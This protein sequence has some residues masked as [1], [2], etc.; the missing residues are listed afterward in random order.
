MATQQ[1]WSLSGQLNTLRNSTP[2]NDDWRKIAL[3]L[4]M[5]GGIASKEKAH[6]INHDSGF[7][8]RNDRGCGSGNRDTDIVVPA[9]CREERSQGLTKP[10]SSFQIDEKSR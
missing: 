8:H 5:P 7:Y 6:G 9:A 3:A 10:A 2:A 1:V 4:K